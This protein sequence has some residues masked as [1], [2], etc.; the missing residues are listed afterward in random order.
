MTRRA[1][2]VL[3]LSDL[4]LGTYGCKALELHNY[5]RSIAPKKIILNGDIIDIWLFSKSY[6]PQAHLLVVQ[7][8]MAFISDGVEVVYVTGNH[9]ELLRKFEGLCLGSLKIV[10]QTTVEIGGSKV[11]IFHGDVFD[12]T[13]RKS[14]WVA[15]LG[16]FSYDFLVLFNLYLNRMLQSVGVR[17]VSLS[18]R[19]KNT[20]KG[21]VSLVDDFEHNVTRIASLKGYDHVVC[22]HIHHPARKR[23]VHEEKEVWYLNSGDWVENLTALEFSEGEWSLYSYHKDQEVNE[24]LQQVTP[25]APLS[26][27]QL[28]QKLLH[29][30][31][32]PQ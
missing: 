22:G 12:V 6:W 27:A 17:K 10:N 16:A 14:K 4:H 26:S 8:L 3:V 1:I 24:I 15:K 5:L 32:I 28:Y 18:K 13:M 30:F 25:E 20:V 2:D 7:E 9:D 21:A 23:F 31:A 29:E 11:W 19:V